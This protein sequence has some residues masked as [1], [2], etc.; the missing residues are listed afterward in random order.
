MK[1]LYKK[2][3]SGFT[4]IEVI[5]VLAIVGILAVG[6]SMGLIKGVESYLFA[7]EATQLSQK[8]QVAM[9]RIKKELTYAENIQTATTTRIAYQS[10]LDGETYVIERSGN[11]IDMYRSVNGVTQESGI[12]IDNVYEA[13]ALFSYFKADGSAWV[14]TP[15]NFNELTQIRV[16][17]SLRQ[18]NGETLNFQTTI[19]PR[20]TDLK[21]VPALN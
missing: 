11:K 19:N 13:Q 12:L 7:G 3:A 14:R 10:S 1:K 20:Q 6:L 17:L 18:S 8:A 15:T 5:I 9:A 21:N 2:S 16:Q 4:L